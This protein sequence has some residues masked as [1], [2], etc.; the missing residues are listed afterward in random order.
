MIGLRCLRS[1][2]LK[3]AAQGIGVCQGGGTATQL[4]AEQ[5]QSGS[6]PDLG[7]I[8]RIQ[9]Q[10]FIS[11]LFGQVGFDAGQDLLVLPGLVKLFQLCPQAG[12][13]GLKSGKGNESKEDIE[14]LG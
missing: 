3:N 14:A 1:S 12:T 13:L 4:P 6:T 8:F 7:L 11:Q 2:T 9:N 5:Y 10:I